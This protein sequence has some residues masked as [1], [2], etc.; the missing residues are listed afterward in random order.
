MKLAL[1]LFLIFSSVAEAQVTNSLIRQPRTMAM[2]GAGVALADDEFALFQNPAGLAGQNSRRFRLLGLTLE[3]S[4]D[5]YSTFGSSL[6]AFSKFN[7]STLNTLMGKDIFLRADLVP[8]I[9]LNHFAIAY[10]ADA[11]GAINQY[12]QANPTF[13]MG[14]QITHGVQAGMG[15]N[16]NLGKRAK[17]EVRVGGAAKVLWRKGGY[18]NIST[19]GFLE[20]VSDSKNYIKNLVGDFGM[21]FGFDLGSQWVRHLDKNTELLGGVSITDVGDTHFSDPRAAKIPMNISFGLGAKKDFDLYQLKV[22]ADLRNLS[23]QTAFVNKTHLGA[24]FS[25]PLF[26]FD[27]GLNQMNLTYG[28]SFDLWVLKVSAVSDVEEL[29]FAYHQQ[30]SRRYMLQVD[31]NLPI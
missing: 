1:F 20:A 15:W 2:G 14:Y 26:N 5:T 19:A 23:Q 18:Y 4:S 31:F 13:L 8:M 11:Q 6:S 27:L 30:A 10:I 21:G 25:I 29:G 3:A 16:L 7:S 28:V 24:E 17:D 12:N 9:T 22:D